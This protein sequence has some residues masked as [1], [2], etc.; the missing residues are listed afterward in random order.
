MIERSH[1]RLVVEE[2]ATTGTAIIFVVAALSTLS[3]FRNEMA[4]IIS[5]FFA[6]AALYA[7]VRS[8]FIADR[9]RGE[10]A[11]KRQVSFWH[12]E[13]AYEAKAIDRICVRYT[14][15]GSGLE[16]RFRSG[17]KKSLTMSLGSAT[18]LESLAGALTHFLRGSP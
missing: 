3:I 10:L 16:V 2:T 13:R 1:Q 9:T 7:G 4:V 18:G 15:K 5:L 17:K 8:R 12:F 11:I 6:S 14:I